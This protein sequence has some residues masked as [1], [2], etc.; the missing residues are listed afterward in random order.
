MR[1]VDTAVYRIEL[2]KRKNIDECVYQFDAV[3]QTNVVKIFNNVLRSMPSTLTV[4]HI[5]DCF[6]QLNDEKADLR[7]LKIHL[8]DGEMTVEENAKGIYGYGQIKV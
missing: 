5:N 1:T 3:S 2:R 4:D 7:S 8:R 6:A